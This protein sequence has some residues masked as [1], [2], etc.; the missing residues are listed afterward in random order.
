MKKKIISRKEL[1]KQ[2]FLSGSSKIRMQIF[3]RDVTPELEEGAF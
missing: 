2:D 1:A 3:A